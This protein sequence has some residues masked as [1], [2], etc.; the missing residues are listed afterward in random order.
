MN[1]WGQGGC[2]KLKIELSA[3]SDIMRDNHIIGG[4]RLLI[5]ASNV[6][7]NLLFTFH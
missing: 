4:E 7:C 5:T 3:D 6:H 1:S 2:C